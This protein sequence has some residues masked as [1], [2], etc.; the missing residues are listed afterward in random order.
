MQATENNKTS[1][2][3]TTTALALL[4]LLLASS[5]FFENNISM[6]DVESEASKAADSNSN[7]EIGKT[8]S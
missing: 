6:L 1:A 3:A 5:K 7:V 2:L 8:S 4:L